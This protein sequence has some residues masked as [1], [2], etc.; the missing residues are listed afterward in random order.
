MLQSVFYTRLL[1]T[2]I[3]TLLCI[4]HLCENDAEYCL[5]IRLLQIR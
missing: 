5:G 3:V 4:A 2:T 1:I